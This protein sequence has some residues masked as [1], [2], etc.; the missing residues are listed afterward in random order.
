MS[1]RDFLELLREHAPDIRVEV[2]KPRGLEILGELL[3]YGTSI[4]AFAG[5][6]KVVQVFISRHANASITISYTSADGSQVKVAYT[7]LTRKE[8]QA[9][10]DAH[11]PSLE[12][13]V[14]VIVT[15]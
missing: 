2:F 14:H 4:G 1:E 10:L 9:H 15:E 12:E 11:P 8:A 13:P 7:A 3:F 6:W 5:L